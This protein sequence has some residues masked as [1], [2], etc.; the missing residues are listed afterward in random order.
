MALNRS[1]LKSGPA[2]LT[3]DGAAIYFQNGVT[4]DEIIETYDVTA[5]MYAG[6]D[7]RL[8]DRYCE[9]KGTPS[10]QWTN[11]G[12][13]FPWLGSPR[14]TMAHGASDTAAVV[15]FLDGD[16]FTYH[17]AAITGMPD[18]MLSHVKSVMEGQLVLQCRVKNNTLVSA[19]NSIFTRAEEAFSDDSFDWEDV[20]TP[21]LELSW[22]PAESWVSFYTQA[23]IKIS[24]KPQWA[25]LEVDGIG[26]VNQELQNLTV[27][28]TFAPVGISQSELDAKLA[29][30]ASD[31]AAQ[32]ARLASRGQDL[33][34]SGTGL[35]VM[36]RNASARKA[37]IQGG[38]AG[39]F[40][41]GDIEAVSS[42]TIT[43]GAAV[44]QLYVGT[45]APV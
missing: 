12:V 34:I 39:R 24:A 31:Y 6:A 23:G 21:V 2:I 14:G 13:W 32:G 36:M 5:D 22:G 37:V 25:A 27:T 18:L 26:V 9:I 33:I 3:Y 41:H 1:T 17:N 35:Y 20:L 38:Q 45:A 40:R 43:D 44:A 4:I 8:K 11:L 10:G 29:I 15:H 42:L 16:K 7:V 30:Q 28:A 19:A